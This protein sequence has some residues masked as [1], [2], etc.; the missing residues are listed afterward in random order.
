MGDPLLAAMGWPGWSRFGVARWTRGLVG[1]LL[2]VGLWLGGAGVASASR[3]TVQLPPASAPS[4]YGSTALDAVA[5]TSR[6]ACVAVGAAGD[7]MTF[8]DTALAERWNGSAWSVEPVPVPPPA[9][10]GD[11]S[12]L[13]D[14]SCASARACFA[15]G[16]A[17]NRPL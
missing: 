5:C 6:T 7:P 12:E 13:I 2:G 10:S 8:E 14:V 16:A 11:G 15:V 3:W 9:R 17:D 1:V 4:E